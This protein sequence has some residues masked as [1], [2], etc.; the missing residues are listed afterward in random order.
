MIFGTNTN[1]TYYNASNN[2][3]KPSATNGDRS[4][5]VDDCNV[6]SSNHNL[7]RAEQS[8]GMSSTK[9]RA[10]GTMFE[11]CHRSRR[12]QKPWEILNL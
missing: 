5:N 3:S 7:N 6:N 1:P 11:L 2:A 12:F 4:V 8:D 9:V 10:P